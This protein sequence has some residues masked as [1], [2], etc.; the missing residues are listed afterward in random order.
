MSASREADVAVVG[1]G[2][3]GLAA[4]RAVVA[5]GAEAVVLEAR[6]RVGGRVVNAEIGDGKVVE[7]GGQWV[8]P[9]QERIAAM[10]A[11]LGVGTFP[12]HGD[13]DNLLRVGG[14]L[15]RYSGTIPRLSPLA[16]LDV[17]L[18]TRRLDRLSARI[19]P[20]APWDTPG[21]AELDATSVGAWIERTMRSGT[22]R[23]LMRVAG[24]TIWGA[25]P[26]ELSLLHFA[27]YL[28]AAGG[29]EML[30]D[31]EG[32]AQQDRFEG[33][34][35]LVAIRAAEELGDRVLLGA[36]ARRIEHGAAGVTV[37][38]DGHRVRARRAI[39]AVPPPLVGRIEFEPGLPPA[40]RQLAQRMPAGWLVKCVALYDQPFWREDGFSGEAL[41]EA[42]PVTMTFD[43][44]P[45]DGS[46]GALVGFVG[47]ADA[48][49]FARLGASERRAA[50]LGSFESL[51]GPKARAAERYIERDWAAEE[52][53]GGGPV[54]N[55][56]TGGWTASGPALREPVG[57]IHWAGTETATR[58]T[59]YIDGAVRSGERAAAAALA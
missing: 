33:G 45:P 6:D 36:P 44:S 16:L 41:N 10:A 42:G 25:E 40:R 9:T 2:F 28:R 51:F 47:G 8:G 31:V 39:V 50:V 53:S 23:R 3:A 20:E 38:A 32:G 14:K 43:N 21:A 57:P 1:A 13:G 27:F 5:A 54:A 4:A 12:T 30:T 24:R 55:F 48:R 17:H 56:A 11:E 58:W 49:R 7:M 34:S 59:G 19:D 46:P 18:A 29:F 15:R 22:A 37:D 35:Q 26:E 52:W